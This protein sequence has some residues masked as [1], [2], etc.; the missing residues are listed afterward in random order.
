MMTL[1]LNER[2]ALALVPSVVAESASLFGV[3]SV[4]SS[5]LGVLA[6]EVAS[7]IVTDAFGADDDIE[8]T[9]TVERRPGQL[10]VIIDD[11]GAP[12]SFARG[13]YPPNV[14]SLVGIG[15]AD[16]LIVENLGREGNRTEIF[17][18]LSYPNVT[19]DAEFIAEA[20]AEQAAAPADE[21]IIVRAMTPDDVHDVARLFFRTYGYTA[22]H[23]SIVYEP[24]KLAEYVRSGHHLATVAVTESGRLIGHLASEVDHIGA[25]TGRIGLLAVDPDYRGR[26]LSAQ[27]GIP[28][29][30]RLIELGFVGQYTEAVAVHERSQKIALATG[31]HECGVWLAAQQPTMEYRGFDSDEE[32]RNSVIIMFGAFGNVPER[33]SYV[34]PSYAS[35]VER[36]YAVNNLV[37]TVES[38][39]ATGRE[40]LPEETT[41]TVR[42]K[43][44]AK[45]AMLG[46]TQFG[47]DFDQALQAQLNQLRINRF[48]VIYLMLPLNDPF[49]AH[50]GGGLR[51]L[52]LSFAGV[53]PEYDNG[54]TLCLQ[55]FVDI[56]VTDDNIATASEFGVEL[57][58]F[59]VD[60][61]RQ[62]EAI[63]ETRARS[64]ARMARVYEAL[65]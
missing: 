7:A 51:E 59:V 37:R 5:R 50:F 19:E 27:L 52:G 58:E 33:V 3:G 26:Q 2:R 41:F 35:I 30:Q 4:A 28:H 38:P 9:F 48:E 57:L 12:S 49:T 63:R 61:Y 14:A 16:D 6:E 13:D 45:V 11:K 55:G 46:V 34:P 21:Q 39:T 1:R 62:A 25:T 43:H 22:Y 15:F 10:A 47:S 60:D 32:H 64:R 18:G 53:Y 44:E 8:L 42:L 40:D 17:K 54:D 29:V 20:T 36:I 24:E 31:A 65:E 56:D 23:A